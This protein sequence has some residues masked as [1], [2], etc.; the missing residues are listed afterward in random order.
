MSKADIGRPAGSSE[1][2][3]SRASAARLS[4]YLRQLE[5][6]RRE[7]V[8]KVSSRLLAA[9]LGLG[10]AQVR[11]DLAQ[12]GGVGHP[13]I[14]YPTAEL[15]GAIR[16]T[17]GLDREWPVVLVGVGNLAR[18][19]LRYEGFRRQGF[20][21]GAVFDCDPAK[22]GQTVEGLTVQPIEHLPSRVAAL[23]AEIGIVTVPSEAAQSVTDRLIEAGVRGILN[24][25]PVLLRL[26]AGVT[27]VSVDL[28][29]Q[30]EQLAFLIQLGGE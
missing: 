29:V 3:P 6:F 24:F 16:Q 2:R 30:L 10:D 14:G 27:Q 5:L 8:A 7:G 18:A 15:I 12:L 25:A 21:I 23:R 13:G 28:S 9:A 19:L 4:L 11:R 22:V 20:R 17:L 1:P 26:P